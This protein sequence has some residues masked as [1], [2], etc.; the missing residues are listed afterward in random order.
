MRHTKLFKIILLFQ[1]LLIVYQVAGQNNTNTAAAMSLNSN[2]H[3][4]HFIENKGQIIDQYGRQRKDIDFRVSGSGVDMFIGSGQIHYQWTKQKNS[5]NHFHFKGL[6]RMSDPLDDARGKGEYDEITTYRMDVTL[7]NAN[8]Q[9]L[10]TAFERQE[11]YEQYYLPQCG[12]LGAKVGAFNKVEYRNVYPNIDWVIYVKGD[13]V[14]Y[15]FVVHPG[16]NVSDIKLKYDGASDIMINLDGS[17]T[18]TTP[19]GPVTENRPYS[20]IEGVTD[21]DS[22]YQLDGNVLSF[23]TGHYK[24]TLTIDPVVKW[25]TYYGGTGADYGTRIACDGLGNVYMVGRTQSISNIAT[26]GSHQQTFANTLVS[27]GDAYLVKFDTSGRRLFATYYGGSGEDYSTGVVVDA[28]GYI[29][30]CGSTY[31]T[32]GIATVNAHQITKKGTSGDAFLVKFDSSGSRHWAT[33]F[34]SMSD[35]EG[36]AIAL[37]ESGCVYMTGSVGGEEPGLSTE[38][39]YQQMFGGGGTDA[40]LVKFDSSGLQKWSTYFGGSDNDAGSSVECK[41]GAVYIT[42]IT[43]SVDNIATK[44]SHQQILAAGG[45]GDAYLAKFDT[46]GTRIWATYYGGIGNGGGFS[47]AC[48]NFGYV[49]MLGQ[50]TGELT[51][52]AT[53]GSHQDTLAGGSF[54]G[55]VSGDVYLVKFDTSGIRQWG[56]YYGGVEVE[57][58]SSVICDKSGDVYISGITMSGDN[59]A[60]PFSH[61]SVYGGGAYD[62]FIAKF[63]SRGVRQWGSYYGGNGNEFNFF[64]Y[65]LGVP[66]A[67]DHLGNVY[68]GGVTRST[69]NIATPSSYQDTL[70]GGTSDAFLVKF[71]FNPTPPVKISGADSVCI[72]GVE[73]YAVPSVEG[74]TSYT[75]YLPPGWT[76]SSDSNVIYVTVDSNG[77]TIGAAAIRCDTSAIQSIQVHIRKGLPAI[78][79]VNGFQLGTVNTHV[80]YQ[81]YLNGQPI[82]GATSATYNVNQNGDYTVKTT[83]INGCSDSSS[84]YSISNVNISSINQL[85]ELITVYPNPANDVVY[86]ASPVDVIV[87][88]SSI[89]GK[90]LQQQDISKGHVDI[91]NLSEGIY[92]LQ[93]VDVNGKY[94]KTEKVTKLR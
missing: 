33:Y 84:A 44:W 26:I 87:R 89:D 72:G 6:G 63:N 30:I 90:F 48:D 25:A 31:S 73:V 5:G 94:L 61:Q 79:T 2:S 8:R 29:Y 75:W 49:Y 93:I 28:L 20:F 17:L 68:L 81:W 67:A 14:E 83:D 52:I 50:T 7:I 60:T 43:Q 76:G 19:M 3:S 58:A 55:L 35:D 11:Y 37:D 9:A 22:R 39:S 91:S 13:L 80:S 24:G 21:I 57:L 92:M 47:L 88:I 10:M 15:D 59:I 74:A 27:S 65:S 32:N 77:G 12:S 69:S 78:I 53:V 54:P 66:L 82:L 36:R 38:G 34:G 4:L 41:S 42:G 85:N 56:S 23:K 18:T 62:A 16:G 86:I 46:S 45:E 40:F 51:N 1:L 70:G 64:F 71:C